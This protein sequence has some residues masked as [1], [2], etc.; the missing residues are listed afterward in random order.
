[1]ESKLILDETA[2]NRAI[3]RISFEILEKNKGAS[4]LLLMGIISRGV[5]LA[6]R[7]AAKLQAVEGCP[8]PVG[9]LDITAYRDDKT[10]PENHADRSC[11]PCD[12]EGKTVVLVDH[13]IYTGRSARSAMEAVIHRGRPKR[14]QLA[15]LVDRGHRELP[16][17]ADF[18]G[19]NLPTSA[20][21]QVVVQLQETDGVS[22]VLIQ[23]E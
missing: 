18:V 1:M 8:V 5:E 22:Q 9:W 15:V 23:E 17:R 21:E 10:P 14:I 19:K 12:I 6:H 3:A 13:V 4:D 11:F 16:I 2:M 7:I 20:A